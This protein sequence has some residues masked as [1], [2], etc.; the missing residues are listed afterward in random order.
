MLQPKIK[1]MLNNKISPRYGMEPGM[2]SSK[3]S[4][5][6][7]VLVT[8]GVILIFQST[9]INLSSLGILFGALGIGIGFG[10]QNIT[11]N[12]ISGIIILFE[13]LVKMGV[14]I[15][16]GNIPSKRMAHQ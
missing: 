7:Y 10:L 4:V 8:I 1:K 5:V 12:L 2:S 14:R 16:V 9:V 11:N 3:A 13:R 15:E 6:R